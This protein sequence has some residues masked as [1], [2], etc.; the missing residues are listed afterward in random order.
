MMDAGEL[1]ALRERDKELRCFYRVSEAVADKHRPPREVFARVLE[2]MPAGWQHPDATGARIEYFG[3]SYTTPG[4]VGAGYCMRAPLFVWHLELGAVEVVCTRAP[5]DGAGAAFL[6]EERLLLDAIA[7]ELGGYLEWKQQA[8]GG[9]PIG[10]SAQHWRWRQRFAERLAASLDGARFGVEAVYLTG[11]T[12][13]GTAGPESDVDLLLV[14]R[15][16]SQQRRELELWLEGWS[17]CLAE[18]AREAV[19]AP[20]DGGLLDVHFR[21]R[22][23]PPSLTLREL[24]L[25]SSRSMAL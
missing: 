10:A 23:P 19:G 8:L 12:E 7:R 1:D 18:V 3:R 9:E 16:T 15:G 17:L 21:D 13:E 22:R 25:K 14:F 6:P 5:D 4:F 20:A 2:A 11:S 24:P